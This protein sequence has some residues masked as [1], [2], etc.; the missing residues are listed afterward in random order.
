MFCFCRKIAPNHLIF[1]KG[2]GNDLVQSNIGL[3]LYK[4]GREAGCRT[5]PCSDPAASPLGSTAVTDSAT[6]K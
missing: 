4:A 5:E 6:L 3:Q 1:T 2:V